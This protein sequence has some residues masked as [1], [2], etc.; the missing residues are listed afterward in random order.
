MLSIYCSTQNKK[1]NPPPPKI[2][3]LL[4]PLTQATKTPLSMILWVR[5]FRLHF[6]RYEANER[7]RIRTE[8]PNDNHRLNMDLDLQ[9]LFG[10]HVNSCTHQ[11]RPSQPL[12]LIPCI[13]AHLGAIGRQYRRHR[14]FVILG[15][16]NNAFCIFSGGSKEGAG[17]SEG[18]IQSSSSSKQ[19]IVI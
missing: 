19:G 18:D 7:K 13:W 1:F 2:N 4:V 17:D 14:F 15:Q 16:Y 11:L 5:H 8:H 6:F 9:C 10:L 12:P 3:S